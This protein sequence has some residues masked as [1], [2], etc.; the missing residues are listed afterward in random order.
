MKPLSV[1][2]FGAAAALAVVS[3][4]VFAQEPTAVIDLPPLDPPRVF[5]PVFGGH[6]AAVEFR[7]G[8]EHLSRAVV[9]LAQ[10]NSGLLC[11]EIRES[12]I[13]GPAAAQ[14]L[15]EP[16]QRGAV[17]LPFGGEVYLDTGRKYFLVIH[18]GEP[19][20]TAG[21]LA[22]AAA[23]DSV[24]SRSFTEAG[25]S[26]EHLACRLEFSP[27]TGERPERRGSEPPLEA[28]YEER[29]AELLASGPDAAGEALMA[30]PEGPT[31]ENVEPL[32]HPLFLVGNVLTE[33]EVYYLA[34]GRPADPLLGGG[35]CAL[36]VADGSEIITQ[37][38][39]GPKCTFFVGADGRERFGQYRTRLETPRLDSGYYPILRVGYTDSDGVIWEQESFA[40]PLDDSGKLASYVRI[41]PR[42]E[43]GTEAQ[44]ARLAVKFS[45][46]ELKTEGNRL[47]C[48]Q[49][50][51]AAVSRP[52]KVEGDTCAIDFSRDEAD[53]AVYLVR[54]LAPEAGLDL[55][56][57]ADLYQAARR[58]VQQYWDARLREGILFEVPEEYPMRAQKNALIQNLYHGWRYSIG[59]PYEGSYVIEGT[60]AAITMGHYGY[61]PRQRAMTSFLMNRPPEAYHTWEKGT[62]LTAAASYYYTSGDKSLIEENKEKFAEILRGFFAETEADENGLLAKQTCCGDIP[63][64]AYYWHHQAVVWRGIRD[65]LNIWRE[66]GDTALADRFA[67]KADDFKAAL[68]RAVQKSQ[69]TLPDGSLFIPIA[70]LA[71]PPELPNE[72]ITATR[73]GSYWNLVAPYAFTSWLF[74]PDS[75]QI[76]GT[77][78]Y[79]VHHGSFL[80]GLIRFNYYPVAPG[81]VKP[82][83]LPGYKADGVDNIYGP[84]FLRLVMS[85]NDA[86]RVVLMFYAKLLHGMTRETFISGEGDTIG[87]FPGEYY[88][89]SYLPPSLFGNA[90]YLDLLRAMLLDDTT[91][92]DGYPGD[93]AL[94]KA[95]PRHWLEA[96][97]T[98]RFTGAPT[99]FGPVSAALTSHIDSGTISV[100]VTLPERK[101]PKSTRLTLRTPGRRRLSAVTVNGREYT[102]FSAESET[103][104]LT[105]LTGTVEIEARFEGE[106]EL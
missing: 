105:G 51:L 103:I 23:D 63:E 39:L 91:D 54:P 80:A 97:K 57:S 70:L 68:L 31:M 3:A 76:K 38:R 44:T 25:P 83:G 28:G 29:I 6:L 22:A 15:I 64:A 18:T 92:E 69:T 5:A 95:T 17:E 20:T 36:H 102:R 99:F 61:V 2:C 104:D 50:V 100:T 93:L 74:A 82:D 30:L 73:I 59:N 37:N 47:L 24:L 35:P 14:V 53:P 106:G 49:T 7:A 34:F 77:Y 78:R 86:D 56:V 87:V 65:I 33:S 101:Q 12:E 71:D 48:G 4:A 55:A 43:E 9:Y 46:G 90:Y 58:D 26:A 89:T 16:G 21:A 85:Q 84:R 60:D 13:N 88:R 40:A 10:P 75:D 67:P 1:F 8:D 98:I 72:R 41:A 96:G 79:C 81:E 45:E 94:F 27:W 66:L 42:W 52:A 32:L 62:Y 11:A 19:A